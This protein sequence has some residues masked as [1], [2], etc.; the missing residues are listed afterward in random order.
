MG[1]NFESDEDVES[2]SEEESNPKA[3]ETE[4]PVDEKM[5]HLFTRQ[6]RIAD[7]TVLWLQDIKTR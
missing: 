4:L 6:D 3:E 7:S 5:Q 1:D 2:N